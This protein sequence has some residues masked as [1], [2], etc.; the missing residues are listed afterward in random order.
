MKVVIVGS[1]NTGT[2]L[3]HLIKNSGH[4]IVRVISRTPENAQALAA[5]LNCSF[6][7]LHD[8]DYGD[9]DLYII[10]L[11]D[12]AINNIEDLVAL[13]NKFIVHT[14]GSIPMN[15]LAP[16]SDKFGVLYPLQSLSKYVDRIPEIPL[17]IDGNNPDTFHFI[18]EFAKTISPLVSH[19]NDKQ[20]MGYH[21]AAIFG[22]NYSNHMF[23]L[24][25]IYCQ[26]EKLDFHYLLPIIKEIL[27]RI[28]H[29]SPFLTQTGPAIR[30]DV[31]TI[32]KHLN[33]L[34]Q[35]EDLK[36]MYLKIAED[37]LKIHGRP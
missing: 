37:I 11:S 17:L 28:S 23:A 1:G 20:R 30:N 21:I 8:P 19:A 6:G 35:Y 22:A 27:L 9:A 16:F 15:A 32:T 18:E 25:E 2:V 34:N 10:C 29:F 12:F 31:F 26:R 3:G 24:A 5:R 7:T 33:T 36:Y 4:E 13:K 14:A